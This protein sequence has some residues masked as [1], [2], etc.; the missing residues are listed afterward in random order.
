MIL[1]KTKC[2]LKTVLKLFTKDVVNGTMYKKEN[3]VKNKKD[4]LKRI[5]N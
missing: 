5:V 1:L 3:V 4:L 2:V